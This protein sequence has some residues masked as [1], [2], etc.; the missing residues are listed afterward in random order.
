MGQILEWNEQ[1]QNYRYK[2]QLKVKNER[3]LNELNDDLKIQYRLADQYLDR[4]R[5]E[6]G[7]VEGLAGASFAQFFLGLFG[8]LDDKLHEEERDVAEAKL[9][10]DEVKAALDGMEADK[11]EVIAQLVDLGDADTAYHRLLKDKLAWIHEHDEQTGDYLEQ[12]SE[13]IGMGKAMLVEVKEAVRA[14]ASV[15]ASLERAKEQLGSAQNW[16]T[17]DMLGGGMI[18]TAIKHGKIDDAREHVHEAQ[19]GLRRLEK[20]LRDL[21]WDSDSAGI[22]IGGMLT[23]ADYFFDGLLSDWIVQGKI[24]DSI[25]SVESRLSDMNQLINRLN[26]EHRRLE[27]EVT[28]YS[29][30]YNQVVELFK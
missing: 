23:F 19:R 8:R 3:R 9:K 30:E 12:L 10:Y 28:K 6:E 24:N 16:G 26:N 4:L 11:S 18:S 20:E 17:Y 13:Q 5:E 14:A 15:I 1:L 7:D 22:K 29:I 21:K 25:G 27:A 2:L